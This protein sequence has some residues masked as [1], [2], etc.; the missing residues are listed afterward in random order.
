[1]HRNAKLLFLEYVRPLLGPGA[2]VLEIGPDQAHPSTLCR[3]AADPSLAWETV[4]PFPRFPVT[5]VSTSEYAFPVP[6]A[7]YDVV[8]SANVLEHVKQPW[9]WFQELARVCKPGGRVVTISPVNWPYHAFPV[10]CWRLHPDGARALFEHAGLAV[11]LSVAE[12]REL[13][14]THVLW[15]GPSSG[16]IF[17]GLIRRL[18]GWNA[19]FLRAV[20]LVSIGSKR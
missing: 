7:A 11:D 2:K 6:D 20:D 5:H 10:D 18:I 14:D 4:E 3:L 16:K 12:C 1:M 17:K 15:D 13:T 8:L 9:T 19:P